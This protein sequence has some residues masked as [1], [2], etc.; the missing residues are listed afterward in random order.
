MKHEYEFPFQ[1]IILK[2]L[3]ET[4]IEELRVLRNQERQFFLQDSIISPEGQASWY[5]KYLTKNNDIMF[6]IVKK[7]TPDKFVGAI[8]VYDIDWDN[9]TA[10]FGRTVVDKAKA[11]EKGIG[12]EATKAVCLFAFDVLKIKLI[13]GE[14]IKTNE[15]I[16]KVYTR[17]GFYI[18]GDYDKDTYLIEMTRNTINL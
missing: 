4:D 13:K 8:A 15:R 10:E 18:S 14:V 6:K 17:A 2:P 1:Q 16:L 3:E 12:L 11:P 5:Q 9:M 7:D